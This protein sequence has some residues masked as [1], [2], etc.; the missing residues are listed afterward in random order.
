[1]ALIISGRIVAMNHTDPDSVFTGRIYL[2][3]DGFI[4][5]VK[6][7][8]D[9]PPAGFAGAPI[10]EVGDAFVIPGLIDLHNHLAYNV[11]PLWA[12]PAQTKPF[13]HHND[14]TNAPTYQ[15]KISWPASVLAKAEPEAMLAYVQARALVGGTTAI[16]GWPA[17]NRPPV[18]V[19][20]NIDSERAGT[21]NRNLIYTSALTEQPVKLARIAGLMRNGA[22]FI[23]HCAEGQPA[24]IVAREFTDLATAG[25]LTKTLIAIH[26][27]AVADGDWTRWDRDEAGAVVWSPFSNL[28][29]Y[30]TTT[31]IPA[32]KKRGISICLGADWGPS[33]TKNVLGELKVAKLVSRK[34]EFGLEDRELVA[35]VT[36]NPGDMLA[37]C[38]SRQIGRL[39]P[40][41]F[42]DV[43]VIRK[44]GNGNVWSQIVAAT[45]DDVVL[46]AVGGRAR[47]GDSDAMKAAGVRE[48]TTLKIKRKGRHLSIPDPADPSKAWSWDDIV[49]RLN[50]VRE[51]PAGALRRRERQAIGFAEPTPATSAP[52]ELTLDMP[53]GGTVAPT[54][55][56]A[57][58]V[59][60]NPENVVIPP[61]PTLV[62]DSKFFRDVRGRGFHGGVLDGLAEFYK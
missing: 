40:G 31:N 37:R 22:G 32:V 45:E 41:G 53:A 25:C 1:M 38:W 14:W 60:A 21:T 44:N 55:A 11:L 3:D 33:G 42:G 56:M 43:T 59:P 18:M 27:N 24:S 36:S 46:V 9:G 5:G 57:L 61:L 17:Y 49:S 54:R 30:G 8:H 16:Q 13:L 58:N 48:T 28:W 51:D 15:A 47:Y 29:L 50:K 62:H 10:V 52:L 23:Y 7:G 4:E 12:E 20:R 19:V 39:V 2:G 35:M 6:A 34:L 26:C